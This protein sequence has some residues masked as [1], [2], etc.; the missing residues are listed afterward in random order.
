MKRE[1]A[2][3]VGCVERQLEGA[4]RDFH[5]CLGDLEGRGGPRRHEMELMCPEEMKQERDI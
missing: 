3:G 5:E 1:M 4:F 2:E